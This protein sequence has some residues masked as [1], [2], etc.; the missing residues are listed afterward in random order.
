MT[1]ATQRPGRNLLWPQE[2]ERSLGADA[3][4]TLYG[5]I[6]PRPR[7]TVAEV[8]RCLCCDSNHIY[9]LIDGG[10]LDA[11]DISQPGSCRALYRIYRYSLVK[12]LFERERY[13]RSAVP[14]PRKEGRDQ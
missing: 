10:T 2:L 13:S 12:F 4:A 14:E 9:R 6:P 7:L 11:C 3:L 1:Q 8:C 5:D